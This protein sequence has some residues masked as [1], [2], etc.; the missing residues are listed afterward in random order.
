[1]IQQNTNECDL[2]QWTKFVCGDNI[3]ISEH[4]KPYLLFNVMNNK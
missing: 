3:F 1:M 4:D 2:C